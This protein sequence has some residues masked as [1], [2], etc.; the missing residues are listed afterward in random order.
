M[1]VGPGRIAVDRNSP[2]APVRRGAI[3][4]VVIPTI[5]RPY[6]EEARASVQNQ[7]LPV[8]VTVREDT[9]HRGQFRIYEEVFELG[10]AP[11]V[12]FFAD[13]D[14]LA[15]GA[16]KKL[17]GALE[18]HPDAAFS[19]G[20]YQ[21]V[22]GDN[23]VSHFLGTSSVLWRRSFLQNLMDTRGYIFR[24]FS[25]TLGEACLFAELKKSG[26]H[27]VE[28]PEVVTLSRIHPG[29]LTWVLNWKVVAGILLS[30]PVIG[31]GPRY[32]VRRILHTRNGMR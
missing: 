3:V 29:Q 22:G 11:Y 9:H 4:D 7:G 23:A 13:D 17:V 31:Y 6:L 24:W 18:A 14:A 21:H 32:A 15:P 20:W 2:P 25:F 26:I 16:L 27:G 30:A 19:W 10:R 5:G 8:E 1:V 12:L 28:A